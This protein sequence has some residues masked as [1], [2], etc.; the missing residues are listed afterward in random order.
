MNEC[1]NAYMS[2]SPSSVIQ[3]AGLSVSVYV[4][5]ACMYE[6][7]M[8]L[9]KDPPPFRTLYY[10]TDDPGIMP[11]NLLELTA[12]GLSRVARKTHEQAA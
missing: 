10:V 7:Q 9:C 8:H 4:H 6:Y 1:R 12:V 5:E 2:V 11:I 3:S